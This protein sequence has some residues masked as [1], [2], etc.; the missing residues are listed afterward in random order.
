MKIN[1]RALWLFGT[2]VV[3]GLVFAQSVAFGQHVWTKD[4]RNPILSGGA[5]GTW[6]R[7]VLTPWVIFNADSGRYEMWYTGGWGYIGF[8]VSGDGITWTR[9][10]NPVLTSDSTAWDSNFVAAACVLRESGQY[11]MWYTGAKDDFPGPG[12]GAL[13]IGYATSPDGRSWTKHPGNPVVGPSVAGWDSG[14]AGYCSVIPVQGGYMMFYE[15]FDLSGDGIGRAFSTDG[16][17]W[18]KDVLNNPVLTKGAPGAWDGNTFLPRVLAIEGKYYMWYTAETV[19]GSGPW[20]IGL[21]TSLDTGRTW[22]KHP[23]NPVL[24]QGPSG[25]WDERWVGLGSLLIVGDTVRMWYY[26]GTAPSYV[27]KIGHATA[28]LAPLEAGSYTVGAGGAFPTLKQA[29]HRLSTAGILGPVTLLLTDTLYVPSPSDSGSFRLDGPVSGAGPAS[30][31]TIRPADN[32]AVTIRGNGEGA[33]SFQDVSYLTLDGISR[34]GATHLSVHALYN[35]FGTRW[36]DAIDFLGNSDFN[37]IRNLTARTEDISRSSAAIALFSDNFGGPDSCLITES[38]ALSGKFGIYV[39]SYGPTWP[40]RPRGNVIKNNQIGSSSDS[41]IAWGIQTV[42]TD[43]SLIEENH[44][45]H[46][47]LM[48]LDEGGVARVFAINAY[49]ASNA[50]IRNNIV[51]DIWTTAANAT[52]YGILLSGAATARGRNSWIYN[53]MVYDVQN[54]VSS[55]R[56]LAGI[57]TWYQDSLRIHFNS[58]VL[59]ESGD[60]APASGS[61]CVWIRTTDL[62]RSLMNNILVNTRNDDPAISNALYF[63]AGT[64]E[65]DHNDLYVSAAE[66]AYVVSR[67][68]TNYKTL[69]DWQAPGNDPLSVSLMPDFLPPDLHI[70][71]SATSADSLDGL[72][73]PIAGILLDADGDLRDQNIPDIGADEFGGAS[74]A[75]GVAVAAGWNMIS[76]PLTTTGDSVLQL[77]PHSLNDHVYT[78]AGASGYEM[79]HRISNTVG[80]WGKFPGAE[81][82]VISGLARS[83]DSVRVMNGWNMVGSISVPVDTAGI[84]GTPAGLKASQWFAYGGGYTPTRYIQPGRAYWV[85]ASSPGT[86]IFSAYAVRPAVAGPLPLAGLSSITVT[87]ARGAAQTLYFGVDASATIV[88]S[89]YEMPPPPPAGVLDARFQSETAGLLLQTLSANPGRTEFPIALQA[90]AYPLKITW[91]VRSDEQAGEQVASYELNDGVGGSHFKPLGLRGQGEVLVTKPGLTKPVLKVHN[92]AEVPREFALGQNYPNPFNPSTTIQYAIPVGTYGRTSLQV[93]DVLGR[94]VATLVNEAKQPGTYTVRWDASGMA[95][96]TYFYQLQTGRFV[97]VKKLLLLK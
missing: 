3:A 34:D 95:S 15:G 56:E 9:D 12:L 45:Q 31:I 11:K 66:S 48:G 39:G 37:I 23:L 6:D 61:S 8:A 82:N 52:A 83:S 64:V 20:G 94:E 60:I 30:R 1:V 10:L 71:P 32:V 77:F 40:H 51:H 46:L 14:G 79:S 86:F 33:L 62:L 24:T 49:F 38:S 17:T 57:R 73:T 50:I 69:A 19:P 68:T 96:G 67:G 36:N 93:Y 42:G 58:V 97:S 76:N 16:I 26:G 88:P 47:R 29:F 72:G 91:D 7:A 18:Q 5:P 59:Q 84:T 85:K 21:A 13:R 27:D 87:D 70:D 43:G 89:D 35:T 63:D 4:L 81:T 78:F 65:S 74:M 90:E 54:R 75:I 55:S 92:G 25:S 2:V 80:Y 53:N 22:T 28:P 41:M 44:V